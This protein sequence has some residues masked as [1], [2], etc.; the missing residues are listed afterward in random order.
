M[1]IK[2]FL[3][4]VLIFMNSRIGVAGDR[5]QSTS[6]GQILEEGRVFFYQ[7]VTD[8]SSIE[9]ALARFEQLSQQSEYSARA[10]AYIGAL[11]ALKGKHATFP[12]QKLKWVQQGLVKMDQG[13]E[14]APEDIEARFVRAT[15]CFHLPF[16]FNRKEQAQ[17]DFKTI[18]ELLPENFQYYTPE[19]IGNVIQFLE[20]HA[21]LTAAESDTLNRIKQQLE[22]HAN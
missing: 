8:K 21:A 22:S 12:H 1:K 11:E 9:L 13:I 16:F 3:L 18:V 17:V 7:S 19:L 20:A 6:P 10:R 4:L 2:I 5:R 15:T 14:A